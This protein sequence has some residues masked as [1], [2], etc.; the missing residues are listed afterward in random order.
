M[1]FFRCYFIVIRKWESSTLQ[2]LLTYCW[3]VKN[4]LALPAETRP[5]FS[6]YGL[7]LI[8]SWWSRKWPDYR[9]QRGQK[10][11]QNCPYYPETT[12]KVILSRR[13][14]CGVT[15]YQSVGA[16]N[17][18]HLQWSNP[19]NHI[20]ISTLVPVPIW[21]LSPNKAKI[22]FYGSIGE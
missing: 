6:L 12:V 13:I 5:P 20:S 10:L 18:L 15:S 3:G 1:I 4:W 8:F 9:C 7:P 17:W 19:G 2:R 11:T 14:L 21:I 22:Y 16:T